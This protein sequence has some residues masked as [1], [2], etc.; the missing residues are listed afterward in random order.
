MGSHIL[1]N[2]ISNLD[3]R[4]G[5]VQRGRGG[6]ECVPRSRPGRGARLRRRALVAAVSCLGLLAG[7][8]PAGSAVLV[9][10]EEALEL[11]FPE[12]EVERR[13][14]YLDEA[15]MEEARRLAGPGVPITSAL[16]PYYVASRSGEPV[17]VA[18]FDTHRVRTEAATVMVLVGPDDRLRRLEMIAFDEPPDYLPRPAWLAQ[19]Q[20]RPLDAELTLK[21]RI[22]PMTGA[23]LTARGLTAAARRALA[24]HAVI[25]PF[26]K[27]ENR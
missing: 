3:D 17:G 14:A 23:T 12:A 2:G 15:R 25:E 10:Q 11:A 26:G 18:Y 21:K 6:W 24:L 13:T 5:P 27:K 9:T 16:V 7:G 20:D 22:R 19:F 4:C 8:S 1:L